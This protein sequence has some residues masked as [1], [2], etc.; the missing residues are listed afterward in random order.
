MKRL[1]AAAA[2]AAAMLLTA[3]DADAQKPSGKAK[4]EDPP[5]TKWP[6]K[7]QP[8]AFPGYKTRLIE[9][10]TCFI[11][12]EVLEH[13]DDADFERKPLDVLELELQEVTAM[14]PPNLVKILHGCP[15]WVKW[16]DTPEKAPPNVSGRILAVAS[17]QAGIS[18]VDV[19][20]LKSVARLRQ[21]AS[22]RQSCVLLHELSH[23]IHHQ[24]LK[25]KNPN[26]EAVYQQ[27]MDRGLYG[28]QYAATNAAEYFAE[29]SSAY[30]D[31]L[32]YKP[33]NRDELKEYDPVGFKFMEQV[34]GKPDSIDAWRAKRDKQKAAAA[35]KAASAKSADT[36]A[37]K[38]EEK[39][40]AAPDAEKAAQQKLE[41]AES[42]FKA[43]K[44]DK[45]RESLNEILKKY[46]G[47][48]AAAKATDW[49]EKLK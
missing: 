20:T 33:T 12:P 18:R 3:R 41:F 43:N 14:M 46:P 15:I 34:W 5:G 6:G 47:T 29:I 45:M 8:D 17:Y 37:T 16:D 21:P 2:L 19:Y 11:T 26:L 28:K 1:F 42:L 48:A 32:H 44:I 30:L 7:P 39:P 49:L 9:G 40:A 13:A 35:A 36:P 38:P 24:F 27:A 10:F 22:K 4:V 31:K 23:V 25:P